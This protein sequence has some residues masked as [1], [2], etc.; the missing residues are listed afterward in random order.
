M[1]NLVQLR[2]YVMYV[3]IIGNSVSLSYN[4]FFCKRSQKKRLK[5]E[6]ATQRKKEMRKEKKQ[7]QKQKLK[8][9]A[10]EEKSSQY[11]HFSLFYKILRPPMQHLPY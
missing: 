2:G 8:E 5:Q 9:K 7:L 11:T 10:K 1:C 3:N 6:L 4:L